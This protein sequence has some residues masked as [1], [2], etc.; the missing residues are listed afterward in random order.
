[1]NVD[2]IRNSGDLKR[3]VWKFSLIVDWN[4]SCIYFEAYSLQV[5]ESSRHRKWKKQTHWE[6]TMRR[7]S[8]I[9]NPPLPSDVE[10]EMRT[11]YQECIKTLPIRR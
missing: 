1:M 8:N 7:D 9:E 5:E 6:R 4:S 2:I 3:E 11:H 10:A